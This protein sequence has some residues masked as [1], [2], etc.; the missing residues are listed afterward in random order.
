MTQ[1][2]LKDLRPLLYPL[3]EIHYTAALRNFN[4]ASVKML[5]KEDAMNA[6]DSSGRMLAIYRVR[7]L[8]DEAARGFEREPSIHAI[9]RLRTPLAVRVAHHLYTC[10]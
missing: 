6:W 9:P 2:I 8:L 4:S 10:R 3:S 1:I 5:T 7:P